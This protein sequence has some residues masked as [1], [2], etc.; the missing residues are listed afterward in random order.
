MEYVQNDPDNEDLLN[1]TSHKLNIDLKMVPKR[2]RTIHFL[3]E[4]QPKFF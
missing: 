3:L 4:N 1:H 2:D